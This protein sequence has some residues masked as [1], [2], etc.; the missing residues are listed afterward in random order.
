MEQAAF[1]PLDKTWLLGPF[2]MCGVTVLSFDY[3]LAPYSRAR[4]VADLPLTP[5]PGSSHLVLFAPGT[6]NRRDPLLVDSMTARVLR[7]SDGSRTAEEIAE[8]LTREDGHAQAKTFEWIEELFVA[9]LIGLRDRDQ[10]VP[11]AVSAT[12]LR[13]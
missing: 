10:R 8:L 3:E 7:L 4:Q 9:G 6:E 5:P 11:A 2:G 1:V 13:A 12:G